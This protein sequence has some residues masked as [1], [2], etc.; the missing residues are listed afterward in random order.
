MNRN[1]T[2]KT[3]KTRKK[4]RF[5]IYKDIIIPNGIKPVKTGDL[6]IV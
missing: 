1:Q 6:K 4:T 5:S 3:N 2:M